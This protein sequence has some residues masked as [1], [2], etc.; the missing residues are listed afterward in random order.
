LTS[1]KRGLAGEQ[2][3][4]WLYEQTLT[5]AFGDEALAQ[6]HVTYQPDRRHLG[7]VGQPR[8]YETPHRAPQPY[9]WELGDGDWLSVLRL[10]TYAAR[11]HRGQTVHQVPLFPLDGIFDEEA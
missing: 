3:A 9:L 5:I 2:A 4:V 8:L 11:G 1:N 10:P 6:Y 7:T